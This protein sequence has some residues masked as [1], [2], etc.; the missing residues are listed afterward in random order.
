MKKLFL[1]VLFLCSC[2][3]I[4]YEDVNPVI[5]PNTNLLPAM[6]SIVDINNLESTYSSGSYSAFANNVGAGYGAN[7]FA[8]WLQTTAINGTNHKDARVNDVINIFNKEVKEN[9][10]NP[11]GKKKGYIVLRLGYRANEYA[12]EYLLPSLLTLGIINFTGF[13]AGKVTQ[14]LEVEVEIL[15]KNKELIKRYTETVYNSNYIAMYWGYN[16]VSIHRKNAADNMKQALE[17]IRLKI[18]SDANEISKK[19]N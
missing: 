19:L 4:V 15:N 7:N 16:E 18:D 6:D 5:Q 1:V 10:T 17:K 3:S 12:G 11:Y 14:S 9:I 13:P 2:K 8:G